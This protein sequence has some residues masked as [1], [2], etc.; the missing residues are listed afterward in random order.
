MPSL[1]KLAAVTAKH[2]GSAGADS[3]AESPA[4]DPPPGLDSS[5]ESALVDASSPGDAEP[6]EPAATGAPNDQAA[7]HALME[8]Q[9][10]ELRERNRERERK[11]QSQLPLG[12][13]PRSP[14]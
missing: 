8:E 7:R 3:A 9:L 10:R 6:G 12:E 1:E 5:A 13:I 4:G 2:E 14:L 11:L